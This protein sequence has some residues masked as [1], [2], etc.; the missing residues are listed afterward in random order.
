LV[1]ALILAAHL[2]TAQKLERL[3]LVAIVGLV[4]FIV[5]AMVRVLTFLVEFSKMFQHQLIWLFRLIIM[6]VM[7][8]LE[9]ALTHKYKEIKNG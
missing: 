9:L 2:L 4:D 7:I 3:T 5:L 8:C 1:F 6:L